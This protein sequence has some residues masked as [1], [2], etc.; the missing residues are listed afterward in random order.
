M[1]L[2]AWLQKPSHRVA[3]IVILIIAV[4]LFVKQKHGPM[5]L[6]M[7][8]GFVGGGVGREA[9]YG[10]EMDVFYTQDSDAS[11][12]KMIA[13]TPPAIPG[14]AP[15]EEVLRDERMIV[16]NA[17]VS[18]VVDNVRGAVADIG[19]KVR[20]LEGFVN[21]S[22]VSEYDIAPTAYVT[23][24]VP[25]ENFD[26]LLTFLRDTYR[27]VSES[28]SGDDVTEQY[29][30]NEARLN[31]LRASEEQFLEIMERATEIE[32]VLNVQQQLERVRGEIESLE[33]QQEHLSRS[34]ALSTVSISLATE[35]AE[36]PIVD[37]SEKWS[38]L[39]TFKQAIRDFREFLI[40]IVDFIILH[41]L[42]LT[43]G[44]ITYGAYVLW[45]RM[46]RR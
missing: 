8:Q 27:V 20:E 6:E 23:V 25:V 9:P 22:S 28:V 14:S 41:S 1:H 30:D 5:P 13:P 29:V 40:G 42:Y 44:L 7:N 36:L 12:R 45:K 2:P 31:N 17:S 16:R 10:G 15:I 19:A 26:A 21:A 3:A 32:D 35:Q 38:P 18:A 37:P 11:M 46:H 24:R 4:V 33:A 39:A 34:A 43:A